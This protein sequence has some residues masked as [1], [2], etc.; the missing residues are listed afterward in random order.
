MGVFE[1][2]INIVES[3][4]FTYFIFKYH[5]FKYDKHYVLLT[6]IVFIEEMVSSYIDSQNKVILFVIPITLF[7]YQCIRLKK[8]SI[9][10]LLMS[11]ISML[12]VAFSGVS[13]IFVLQLCGFNPMEYLYIVM[14]LS[15]IICLIFM[16]YFN[17]NINLSKKEVPEI[18]LFN[19]VVALLITIMVIDIESIMNNYDT[20]PYVYTRIVVIA[21]LVLLLY[22]FLRQFIENANQK[23]YYELELQKKDYEK[24]NAEII[25]KNKKELVKIEHNLKYTLMSVLFHAKHKDLEAL[26]EHV[27]NYL[28]R[29]TLVNHAIATKNPYFDFVFNEVSHEFKFNGIVLKKNMIISENSLINNNLVADKIIMSTKKILDLAIENNINTVDVKISE[30]GDM[31]FVYY[32][33]IYSDFGAIFNCVNMNFNGEYRYN[34]DEIY[35]FLSISFAIDLE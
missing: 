20:S 18:W 17:V 29:V 24:K 19:L 21:I 22:R 26:E 30:D 25:E 10:N 8:Y 5:K 15:K 1:V 2:F 4:L 33:L 9:N 13:T 16:R 6:T 28:G 32:H 14:L 23:I 31:C 27:N 3:L 34:F 11:I 7:I 12:L 35:K